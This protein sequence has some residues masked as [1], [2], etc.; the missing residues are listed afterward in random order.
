MTLVTSLEHFSAEAKSRAKGQPVYVAEVDGRV[1]VTCVSDDG[2][3]ALCAVSKLAS[4][5]VEKQLTAAGC[6]VRKGEWKCGAV[7]DSTEAMWIGAVAYK[8]SEAKPGLWVDAFPYQPSE[9]EVSQTFLTEMVDQGVV[10]E[11]GLEQFNA[12]ANPNVLVIGPSEIA[13]F[14]ESRAAKLAD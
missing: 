1:R 12:L 2:N 8:S 13:G 6:S 11:I 9:A 5:E 4:D 7:T 10:K 3:V 14:I